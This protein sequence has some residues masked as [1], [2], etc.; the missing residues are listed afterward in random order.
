M[1]DKTYPSSNHIL[2]KALKASATCL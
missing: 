2:V 1:N